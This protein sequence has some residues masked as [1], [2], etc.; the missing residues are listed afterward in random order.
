MDTNLGLNIGSAVASR[1]K[2]QL[3]NTIGGAATFGDNSLRNVRAGWQ[4]RY[5]ALHTEGFDSDDYMLFGSVWNS[6]FTVGP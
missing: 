2:K 5:G 3:D 1:I 4:Q 6:S